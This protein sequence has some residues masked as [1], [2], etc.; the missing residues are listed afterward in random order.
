MDVRITGGTATLRITEVI[1]LDVW[2]GAVAHRITTTAWGVARVAALLDQHPVAVDPSGAAQGVHLLVVAQVA[3]VAVALVHHRRGRRLEEAQG[4]LVGGLA[5]RHHPHVHPLAVEH[6]PEVASEQRGL[7][8]LVPLVPARHPVALARHVP[9]LVVEAAVRVRAEVASL[10]GEVVVPVQAVEASSVA[11]VARAL[12]AADS[13]EA[14]HGRAVVGSL[15]V[16]AA[17]VVPADLVALEAVEDDR[18][19]L[20]NRR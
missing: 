7:G 5:P 11:E 20:C 16:A 6:P 10:E 2:V 17:D 9:R 12:V 8:V 13:S 18:F 4:H 15:V 19:G 3:P 1:R 14:V